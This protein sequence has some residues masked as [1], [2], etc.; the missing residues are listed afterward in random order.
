MYQLMFVKAFSQLALY[1]LIAQH[2]LSTHSLHC[3]PSGTRNGINIYQ[4][5]QIEHATCELPLDIPCIIKHSTLKHWA[6]STKKRIVN[7]LKTQQT[8]ITLE[9]HSSDCHC[10]DTSNIHLCNDYVYS[11]SSYQNGMESLFGNRIDSIWYQYE[12]NYNL[13]KKY[14]KCINKNIL[15]IPIHKAFNKAKSLHKTNNNNSKISAATHP[16]SLKLAMKDRANYIEYIE[17]KNIKPYFK[18]FKMK[19]ELN[20]IAMMNNWIGS[21]GYQSSLHLDRS[22]N[23]YF[24]ISGN[25]TFLLSKPDRFNKFIIFPF[26]HVK[27]GNA[28]YNDSEIEYKVH[29]K[30]HEIF[31]LPSFWWHH[32][33]NG[34]YDSFALNIW[35]ENDN[36]NKIETYQFSMEIKMKLVNYKDNLNEILY[37]IQTLQHK[38]FHGKSNDALLFGYF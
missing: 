12:I 27:T 36:L 32:V 22:D 37:F 31:Y 5:N 1:L 20:D 4:W 6:K 2:L 38:Y 34:K 19:N 8:L 10:F 35:I 3:Q 23:I 26:L 21:T 11:F 24:M 16:V 29:I 28:I 18:I 15:S 14:L 13:H 17:Y 9:S 25:K 7:T 33:I 30:Q